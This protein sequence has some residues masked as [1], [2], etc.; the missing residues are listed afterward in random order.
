MNA[1]LTPTV[2]RLRRHDRLS[3]LVRSELRDLDARL[4]EIPEFSEWMASAVFTKAP[5]CGQLLVTGRVSGGG[6]PFAIGEAT[7]TRCVVELAQR[8]G[9]GYVLG[10]DHRRAATVAVLDAASQG[11]YASEID[12]RVVGP[13]ASLLRAKD[14]RAAAITDSTRVQFD[15]AARG[16][17]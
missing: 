15:T 10:R 16:D 5:Q 1:P 7:V 14:A 17:A 2:T 9:V 3:V 12:A 4:S 13:L 6:E 8:V 11:P